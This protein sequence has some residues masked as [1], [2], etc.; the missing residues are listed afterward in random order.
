MN[1]P[2]LKATSTPCPKEGR[3]RS[4]E[5]ATARVVAK[6]AKGE[7]GP[8]RWQQVQLPLEVR[9]ASVTLLRRG[10]V[11]RGSALDSRC[12]PNASRLEPVVLRHAFRL[13]CQT[14]PP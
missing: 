2:S 10:P 6:G 1:R 12:H 13:V 5:G 4:T 7:N 8:H 11:L 9:E 3:L 14:G